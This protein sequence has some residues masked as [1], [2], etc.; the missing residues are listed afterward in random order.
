MQLRLRDAR[1][2]S[3]SFWKR[4]SRYSREIVT[5]VLIADSVAPAVPFILNKPLCD[6]VRISWISDPR[7]RRP[8]I[9]ARYVVARNGSPVC[10]AC[11]W[12]G[13]AFNAHEGAINTWPK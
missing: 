3:V 6:A 1:C 5:L 9:H 12:F 8:A 11:V 10:V 4:I 2:Q 13:A 7:V